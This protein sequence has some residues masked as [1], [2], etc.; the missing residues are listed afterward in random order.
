MKQA[1]RLFAFVAAIVMAFAVALPAWAE[2]TT[3]PG[4]LTVKNSEDGVTYNF[5]KVFDLTGQDTSNPADGEYDAVVYTIDSNW[6]SFFSGAGASYISNTNTGDLNP[7]KINGTTKYI[8]ITENNKVEFTNAA[9]KY[10]IDNDLG[11]DTTANGKTGSD[12][13]VNNLELGYYLMVPVDMTD[14]KNNPLTSG[15]IAS[16]TST[17]PSGDIYVKATKPTVTK[18]DDAVSAD[19]GQQITYT[20]TGK[21]PNTSG[22]TSF[23]YKL[24][25]E[26]S[27]GLTFNKD[28]SVA[29]DGT[30]VAAESVS[31]WIDYD[32]VTNG[33]V[34][35]IPVVNYQNNIG[36]DI[37][38]TYTA[39]VNDNAVTSNQEKNSAKV[40]YGRNPNELQESVPVEEEVYSAKII[41]NK[42]TDGDSKNGAKLGNAVFALMK[43]DGNTAKFYKYTAATADAP[44]AVTWVSVANAPTSGTAV[45]TDAMATALADAGAAENIT[46]KTTNSDGAASFD[47][48]ADGTYY[49]VEIA[50]PDGYNR[51]DTPQVITVEGEDVDTKHEQT[52]NTAYASQTE[53]DSAVNP[54]ADV[55]N[56]TGTELPSTGGIGTTIFYVVGGLLV[57]GAAV[58]LVVRR[59]AAAE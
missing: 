16:L 32:T 33:F 26:M 52:E 6:A 57:A 54:T 55:N 22:T 58:S 42:Y 19:V 15:T 25:D 29:I 17:V 4:S 20:L 2:E 49:L 9:M 11:T 59:R 50:A 41:I 45:V 47:G 23:I 13:T 10:A 43:I 36:D 31:S 21:V 5:Y 51:L 3:N 44:A 56:Q 1:R 30:A 37:V 18:T 46:V 34:I 35:T 28:V 48:I 38:L 39:T 24:Q 7:I 53:F 12:V 8:N 14:E 27:T 40:I